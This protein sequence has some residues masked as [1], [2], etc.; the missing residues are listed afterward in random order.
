MF[1]SLDTSTEH[2]RCLNASFSMGEISP[3]WLKGSWCWS[4]VYGG[5]LG[6]AAALY[7]DG[8]L[9]GVSPAWCR[10]VL[11]C[12]K[13]SRWLRAGDVW[14][15]TWVRRWMCSSQQLRRAVRNG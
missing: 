14:A 8:A 4:L 11:V 10:E 13:G 1:G 2:F 5:D 3:P 15:Y 7:R 9:V 12:W 6:D